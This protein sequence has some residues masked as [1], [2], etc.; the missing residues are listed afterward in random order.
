MSYYDEILVKIDNLI[1]N[2]DFDT[3]LK[4]IT[5][6]LNMPYVPK[7][8]DDKLNSIL[9]DLP[10][11]DN[12][13]TLSIDEIEKFLYLDKEKQLIAVEALNRLNLRDHLDIC[14]KYL[15]G[16]GFINAKVLLI[17]SLINQ[18]ISEELHMV[19]EGLEYNFIPK[20]V[21]TPIESLGYKGALKLISDTFMKEP[22]KLELAK[23]LLYKECLMALPINYDEN[24]APLLANKV[25]SFIEEAFN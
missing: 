18:D 7:D 8:I 24:D 16:D 13:K 3:A 9:K 17:D 22:S 21:I 4:V 19:N 15:E 25:I 5:N 14:N 20:Y 6:E 2:S 23:S 1:K 10:K 11:D 12:T